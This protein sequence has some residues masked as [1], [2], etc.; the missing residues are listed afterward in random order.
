MLPTVLRYHAMKDPRKTP[1]KP[2]ERIKGS[3]VNAPGSARSEASGRNVRFDEATEKA[4]QKKLREFNAG[5]TPHGKAKIGAL[6]SVARRGFGAFSSSHRPGVSRQAWGLARVDAFLHLLKTGTPKNL[7]YVQ[8]NDLL[9]SKHPRS[10]ASKQYVCKD[11]GTY[12]IEE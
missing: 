5:S 1:A 11:G 7:K 4:L 6:R 12:C 3:R 8:D 2:H 10:T 9:P